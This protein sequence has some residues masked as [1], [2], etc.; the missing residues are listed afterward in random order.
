M[1]DEMSDSMLGLPVRRTVAAGSDDKRGKL[2]GNAYKV[3]MYKEVVKHL[4]SAPLIQ[5]DF[6]VAEVV[7]YCSPTL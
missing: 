1:L 7:F 4:S 3:T 6:F 5:L 2:L